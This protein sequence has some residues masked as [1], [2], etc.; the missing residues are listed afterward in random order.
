MSDDRTVE[1]IEAAYRNRGA[2]FFR[3]ALA[4]TGDRELAREAVQEGFARA[5]RARR[6]FRG[7]GSLEAWIGRCVL[8]AAIDA[9]K[10]TPH[11]EV[12]DRVD[13]SRHPEID[14][15]VW[16]AVR[17]LPG[18]QRDALFLR[19]YLDF[20]YATIAQALNVKTGTVSATLHAAHRNLRHALQEVTS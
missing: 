11:R 1:A 12:H 6:S 5:I 4:R 20:D 19:Y 17:R 10:S 16:D 18:R 13:D 3:F 2:D 8:N 7:T 14:P 9:T 15:E